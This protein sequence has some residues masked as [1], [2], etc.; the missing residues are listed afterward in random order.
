[1]EKLILRIY[2]YKKPTPDLFY[3]IYTNLN[4]NKWDFSMTWRGSINNYVYNNVDSNKG[5]Q[6]QIL[7]RDTDLSMEFQRF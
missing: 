3:G 2:I 7:I 1:M 6:N 5:W 4:Y